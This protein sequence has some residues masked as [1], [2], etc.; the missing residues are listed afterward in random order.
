MNKNKSKELVLT[1]AH[2]S[3]LKSAI[4]RLVFTY[5]KQFDANGLCSAD[6]FN[7]EDVFNVK[8]M[9]D[10]THDG[11]PDCYDGT[12]LEANKGVVMTIDEH[13]NQYANGAYY[14]HKNQAEIWAT[15]AEDK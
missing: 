7:L 9:G 10:S 6:D 14:F 8:V 2:I 3:E 15:K 5:V 13:I 1:T 12:T 11:G 4:N